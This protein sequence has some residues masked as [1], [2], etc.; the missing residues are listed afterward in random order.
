MSA[1]IHSKSELLHLQLELVIIKSLKS[2]YLSNVSAGILNSNCHFN[3]SRLRIVTIVDVYFV[4]KHFI[5]IQKQPPYRTISLYWTIHVRW[6]LS[7]CRTYLLQSYVAHR[8]SETFCKIFVGGG[9]KQWIN[10]FM[11]IKTH[12]GCFIDPGD[13]SVTSRLYSIINIQLDLTE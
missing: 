3:N 11:I 13:T 8:R 10:D 6:T 4:K 7:F 5:L 12:R 9:M 1:S 2:L